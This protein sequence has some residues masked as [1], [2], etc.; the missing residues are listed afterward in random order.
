MIHNFSFMF[1]SIF[2][3]SSLW[4]VL[5]HFCLQLEPGRLGWGLEVLRQL[6]GKVVTRELDVDEVHGEAE[7]LHTEQPVPVG[8]RQ[9]PDLG[10]H[11]VG[12][13]GLHHHGLRL[14]ARHLSVLRAGGGE[15]LRPSEESYYYT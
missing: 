11:G 4:S 1:A 13:L 2:D 3:D 10:Q 7:L 8:V 9:A 5:F 6:G 15:L 14:A 12:Q